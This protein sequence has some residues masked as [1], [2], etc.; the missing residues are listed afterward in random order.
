MGVLGLKIYEDWGVMLVVID[1]V[2][3]VV[4]EMDI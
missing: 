4:D 2:L 1:L 3:K